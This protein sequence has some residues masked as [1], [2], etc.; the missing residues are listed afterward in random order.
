M[1]PSGAELRRVGH[2]LR[3]LLERIGHRHVAPARGHPGRRSASPRGRGRAPGCTSRARPTCT[4]RRSGPPC[5]PLRKLSVRSSGAPN[6]AAAGAA[7]RAA[8]RRRCQETG[9]RR[10]EDRLRWVSSHVRVS[11]SSVLHEGWQGKRGA[12]HRRVVQAQ[13]RAHRIEA[14][15]A[16]SRRRCCAGSTSSEP[17]T[18]LQS[19][20]G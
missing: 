19:M 15:V 13:L 17:I 20:P 10:R 3:D 8:L 14:Q 18:Q 6:M 16:W 9:G 2:R 1:T 7:C 5:A 11:C 12:M 4:A